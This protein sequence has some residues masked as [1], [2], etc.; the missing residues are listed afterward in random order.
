MSKKIT[1]LFED[2]EHNNELYPRTKTQAITDSSNNS[3][4]TILSNKQDKVSNSTDKLAS[5]NSSGQTENSTID[6]SDVSDIID[7]Y[8]NIEELKTNQEFLYR[9]VPVAYDGAGTLTSIKGNTISFNQIVVNGNFADTNNWNRSSLESYSAS[10]NIYSWTGNAQYNGIYQVLNWISGH[11]YYFTIDVYGTNTSNRYRLQ[12]N[13]TD[14]EVYG[15]YINAWE[16]VKGIYDCS[17]SRSGNFFI[18]DL[19]SS[20]WTEIKARYA[21]VF[22]L[23]LMGIDSLTTTAQVEDWLSTHL[24]NLP[25][26]DY[27]PGILIPFTGSGLKT[28]GKNLCD[29]STLERGWYDGE[30]VYVDVSS[31]RTS[32]LIPVLPN[33]TYIASLFGNNKSRIGNLVYTEWDINGNALGQATSQTI[34]TSSKTAFLRI[35]NYQNQETYIQNND[36]LYQLEIGSTATAYEPY[37]SK[38][39]TMPISTYFPTGMKSA[40]TVYDELSDKAYTRTNRV[41]FNGSESWS[42]LNVFTDIIQFGITPGNVKAPATNSTLAN[43][44]CPL[45]KTDTADHMYANPSEATCVDITGR[46]RINI[47]KSKLSELTVSAFQTWLSSNNVEVVYELATPLQNYGVVDLGS[48]NWQTNN[49]AISGKPRMLSSDLAS[50]IK[51][52]ANDNTAFN[53]IC[54]KYISVSNNATYNNTR[55][56]G[57][58]ASSGNLFIYDE[59]YTDATAFKSAMSGVYLL[60]ETETPV[61]P[62]LDLTYPIWVGGTEQILPTPLMNGQVDLGSLNWSYGTFHT[63]NNVFYVGFTDTPSVPDWDAI[64]NLLCSKYKSVSFNTIRDSI[65]GVVCAYDSIV[66]YDSDYTDAT[67]FKNSLSG[68]MLYYQKNTSIPTTTSIEADINYRN[69][70]KV[71]Y[72]NVDKIPDKQDILISGTNIK[73]I[74]N[75]SLLGSGN[76]ALDSSAV[77]LG[78][79][80]NTGDSDTPS[81]GGTDKFT[82]GGAYA[83]DNTL[84]AYADNKPTIL[85]GTSV[86]SASTGKNGD[87]F[88][89]YS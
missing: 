19:T 54:A 9:E 5:F 36:Y 10:N 26:Y 69:S 24:G 20:S 32:S 43:I 66:I 63:S 70:N 25:Y 44:V 86:P 21:M 74:G 67:E 28:T 80:V 45:F 42:T 76:V 50:I 75:Q 23:T 41:V 58:S 84:K 79:V 18:C 27:T 59:T 85:Y 78:S 49:T 35:R 3:L 88:I 40:G 81:L 46:I 77:G 2:A 7:D 72:D 82:T 68:V 8:K 89:L 12:V 65:N 56:I 14:K 47:L 15:N 30:G 73:T 60:Y 87:I 39:L 11:K 33:T 51:K 57:V 13:G 62:S 64:C 17:V 52:P 83:L 4:D 37:Q 34:T 22:D 61:A 55:G 53:G 31:M 38:T 16:T 6:K 1:T 48:L 71:R 29:N